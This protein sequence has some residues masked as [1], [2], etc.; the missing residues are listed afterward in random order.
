M[1][2]TTTTATEGSY[3]VVHYKGTLNDGT[4]F[5]NSR[6]RGEPISFT[7][8]TGQMI[9]GFETALDGMTTG[10]TKTITI[11]CDEAY[12]EA[13]DEA[14]ALLN[15]SDFPEEFPLDIGNAVPLTGPGGQSMMG[16]VFEVQGEAVKIDLNH[17]LAGQDLTFEIDLLSV[18]DNTETFDIEDTDS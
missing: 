8:G 13:D 6:K 4:E 11:P 7:L 15:K 1:T 9:P 2:Q 16:K 12:G 17:P 10:E 18:I 14:Y 5:D 3:V